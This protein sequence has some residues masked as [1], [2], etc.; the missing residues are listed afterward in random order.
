MV[1]FLMGENLLHIGSAG[2]S[3]AVFLMYMGAACA[4]SKCFRQSLFDFLY[5]LGLGCIFFVA[6]SV[7]LPY[8]AAM[9]LIPGVVSAVMI[10]IQRYKKNKPQGLLKNS[11]HSAGHLNLS[12]FCGLW[13]SMNFSMLFFPVTILCG[14]ALGF[15]R[16]RGALTGLFFGLCLYCFS[17]A[18]AGPGTVCTGLVF[19]MPFLLFRKKMEAVHFINTGKD[20]DVYHV[21]GA[22]CPKTIFWMGPRNIQA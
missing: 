22:D 2:I 18:Q 9:V 20:R 19:V 7:D 8:I 10:I 15:S 12:V 11:N 6:G 4:W 14:A 13:L 17:L 1:W 3:L 16:S 5:W 21:P